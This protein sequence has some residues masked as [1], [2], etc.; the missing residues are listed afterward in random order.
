MEEFHKKLTYDDLT[1]EQRD[2]LEYIFKFLEGPNRQ[3]ILTGAAGT[4]K[5]SL[6]N[7]LLDKLD[8]SDEYE[9]TCT[10]PTNKAVGVIAERTGRPFNRTIY[11]LLGLVLIDVGDGK[12]TLKEQGDS[13]FE[14][15]DL[16]ILDEASM[17]SEALVDRI[18]NKLMRHQ[19]TKV[20]Y[21]GDRCQLPPVDD[22]L[23][24]YSESVV[25]Q[26]PLSVNLNTVMRTAKEN[27]ILDAVTAMRVDMKS[28][29]DLFAPSTKLLED[30]SGIEFVTDPD[31]FMEKM[32]SE[33]SSEAYKDDSSHAIAL[34]WTNRA[35]DWMNARIR[36]HIYGDDVDS[37]VKGEEVR[38]V[39]TYLSNADKPRVIYN[40]ED[41]L[42]I[43]A[44]EA[45]DDP[46]YKVPCF[47][48]R[49]QAVDDTAKT[50]GK[51][52][53]YVVQPTPEAMAVY[54]KLKNEKKAE[55]L[56][57]MAEVKFGASVYS[58]KEAWHDYMKLRDHFLWLDY[59]Y[60]LTVH[61]A[62]GSTI[63][64]VFVAGKNIDRAGD[65]PELRNKLKYTAFTRASR[66]L[67]VLL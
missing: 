25:F 67:T 26:L 44:I 58:R 61:K 23:R 62:Q 66:K 10:A 14:D 57:K 21:V 31:E 63:R 17:V 34:A 36:R 13:T 43:H 22:Q 45:M 35:V 6:V 16:V 41:R 51:M 33:F 1:K 27:P 12:P 42:I 9:Y 39:R 5:T 28:R 64:N 56:K 3:M 60:A 52:T 38:V 53:C 37:F 48:M 4:G 54:D 59:I 19:R 20:I 55:A 32:L 8:E 65:D 49:V 24:G 50:T 40:C 11:S 46:K 29:I 2:A 30:G 15:Y 47:K 7:V 18:Q